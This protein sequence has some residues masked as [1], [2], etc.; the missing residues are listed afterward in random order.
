MYQSGKLVIAGHAPAFDHA[1]AIVE[2]VGK[3]LAPKRAHEGPPASPSAEAPPETEPHIGTDE[4]GKGDFFGPLV[5][6]GVYVEE[7][8]VDVHIR[9][10]RKALTPTSHDRLI[11]TVR[12]AGYRF[13]AH[14]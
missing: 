14:S 5:T 8:T 3:P 7:R 2:S 1:V 12:G 10:L 4:A 13:S 9:R 11:Q 6:A